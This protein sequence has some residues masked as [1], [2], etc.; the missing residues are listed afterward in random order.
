MTEKQKETDPI[1]T[2]A[3]GVNVPLS[4]LEEDEAWGAHPGWAGQIALKK[5]RETG[6]TGSEK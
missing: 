5:F 2:V 1:I 6:E 4:A 3:K